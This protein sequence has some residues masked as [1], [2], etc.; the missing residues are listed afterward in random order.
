L[1]RLF[2]VNGDGQIGWFSHLSRFQPEFFSLLPRQRS[3]QEF[4]QVSLQP[5]KQSPPQWFMQSPVHVLPQSL[6]AIAGVGNTTAAKPIAAKAGSILA[7]RR[8]R[9]VVLFGF[10]VISDIP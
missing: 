8:R 2:S 6:Q 9:S 1:S 3:L 5:P 7:R 10:F 4:W